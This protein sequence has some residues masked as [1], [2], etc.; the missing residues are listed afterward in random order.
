M[1]AKTTERQA[2]SNLL[3]SRWE[4]LGAKLE[5]LARE[6]PEEKY[7]KAP[8][9]GVRT[10]GG[11]L[12]HVAFWNQYLAD[13]ACGNKTD[14]AANELPKADYATKEQVVR[15][16]TKS[17]ADALAAL[18]EHRAGLDPDKAA[19]AETF[20]EHVCE[21]YGQLA[22]YARWAGVVPPASRT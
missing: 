17:T 16:L 22:V 8:V 10:F 1:T 4:Q 11:V 2:V 14:D 6:Y 3:I 20:I 5:G 13:A 12:R 19:L 15:A 9:E 18:R 21:H 7:E